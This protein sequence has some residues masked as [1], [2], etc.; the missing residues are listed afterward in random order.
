VG[1]QIFLNYVLLQSKDVK[2]T[3]ILFYQRRSRWASIIAT[4]LG[5]H[6][7]QAALENRL[8]KEN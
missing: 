4:V 3:F 7:C 1:V 6:R 2:K 5:E 8:F